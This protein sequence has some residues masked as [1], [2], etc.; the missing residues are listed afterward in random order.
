MKALKLFEAKYSDLNY[1]GILSW[2]I[3]CKYSFVNVTMEIIQMLNSN[4]VWVN[5]N[6]KKKLCMYS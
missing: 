1:M 4:Q 5:N 6:N 3:V 2:V